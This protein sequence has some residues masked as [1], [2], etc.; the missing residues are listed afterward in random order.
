M[1]PPFRRMSGS[2]PLRG[3]TEV[4]VDAEAEAEVDMVGGHLRKPMQMGSSALAV[5]EAAEPGV[6][7]AAASADVVA[8]ENLAIAVDIVAVKE[9]DTGVGKGEML[10]E[11]R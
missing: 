8:S 1:V 9:A 6:I 4:A 3:R 11:N 7:I 2:P 5:G 10:L